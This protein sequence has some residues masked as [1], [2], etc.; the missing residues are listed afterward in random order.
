[1]SSRRC[2]SLGLIAGTLLLPCG[3]FGCSDY[4]G[5]VPA[6][7]YNTTHVSYVP[8]QHAD[9]V[10][11]NVP[12]IDPHD[13]AVEP[14]PLPEPHVWQKGMRIAFVGEIE[15]INDDQGGAILRVEV[16]PILGDGKLGRAKANQLMALPKEGTDKMVYRMDWRAPAKAGRYRVVV[17]SFDEAFDLE[18]LV[19][20][21]AGDVVVE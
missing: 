14:L 18:N 3:Q 4:T 5:V 16:S 9:A 11:F 12:L 6:Q 13:P 1:M 21:V 2:P 17:N 20:F 7:G 8:K 19:T 10:I 15:K